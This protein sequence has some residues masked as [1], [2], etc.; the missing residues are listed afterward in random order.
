MGPDKLSVCISACKEDAPIGMIQDVLGSG[1]HPPSWRV[2]THD[3]PEVVFDDTYVHTEERPSSEPRMP[4]YHP[5]MTPSSENGIRVG[6]S[7]VGG[8]VQTMGPLV[9]FPLGF[10]ACL[11]Q[12][13][14]EE[15]EGQERRKDDATTPPPSTDSECMYVRW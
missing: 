7:C 3:E 5:S 8:G 2:T 10:S 12:S 9:C 4:R 15:E 11:A 6:L 14:E 1:I 13:G